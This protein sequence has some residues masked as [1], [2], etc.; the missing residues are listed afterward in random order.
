I[1]LCWKAVPK[2]SRRMA[3]PAAEVYSHWLSD[4]VTG[5]S[6]RC[7]RTVSLASDFTR[8]FAGKVRPTLIVVALSLTTYSYDGPGRPVSLGTEIFMLAAPVAPKSQPLPATEK[9]CRMT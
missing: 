4:S 8:L 5:V 1:A 9:P 3:V 2:G 7:A 6:S